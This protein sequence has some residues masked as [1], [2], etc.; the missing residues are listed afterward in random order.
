MCMVVRTAPA[1]TYTA[2]THYVSNVN[3]FYTTLVDTPCRAYFMGVISHPPG[4][5]RPHGC[6]PHTSN[7][8][9]FIPDESA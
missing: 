2:Y 7:E 4:V 8:W 5:L 3:T 6:S 9:V 1:R